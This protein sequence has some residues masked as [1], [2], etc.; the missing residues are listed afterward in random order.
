MPA[1]SRTFAVLA[2][3]VVSTAVAGCGGDD[4]GPDRTPAQKVETTRVQVVEQKGGG[5]GMNA[6]ALYRRLSPGVVTVIS[7]FDGGASPLLDEDG[8]GGQGSGFVLDAQGRIATNAHVVTTGRPPRTK[9]AKEVFVAFADG[10][11]VPAKIVGDDPNADVALL[12]VD[13]QGL[14]LTP[15]KLGSSRNLR[16]GEPVA[17]IGSPFSEEQSLSIGVISALNRNIESLTAF[18]IGDAI[19]TDAAINPGNSGG[20]LLSAR[21]EVLGI[22]AQIK[23]QSGGGEGVGFAVPVG[24]VRRSLRELRADGRVTYGYLG[25][26]TRQLYPQLAKKLE[27]DTTGGALITRVED[28]S[29]AKDAGLKAGDDELDFQIDENL[30]VGGDVIVAVDGRKVTR[31]DDLAD[32]VSRRGEGDEVE[33]EVLRG[34]DRRTVKVELGRRPDRAPQPRPR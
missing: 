33:L 21:G 28:D 27:L 31:R 10:N 34:D 14:S 20:P 18:Q 6:E 13:P 3:A 23:S 25:V 8:E 24:A 16:V 4:S 19:Q 7:K 12:E 22:N 26:E 17:A 30:K 2:V 9:R 32:L 11:Q 5:G 29:P 15:L 1:R